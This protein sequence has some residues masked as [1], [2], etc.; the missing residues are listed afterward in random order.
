MHLLDDVVR[1]LDLASWRSV[2][3]SLVCAVYRVHDHHLMTPADDS[4]RSRVL[5]IRIGCEDGSWLGQQVF[6]ASLI[7]SSRDEMRLQIDGARDAIVVDLLPRAPPPDPAED[8]GACKISGAVGMTSANGAFP[9]GKRWI[10]RIVADSAADAAPPAPRRPPLTTDQL[11]RMKVTDLRDM[12]ARVGA[13]VPS[14]TRRKED[15]V[16]AIIS[17]SSS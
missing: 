4:D 1:S 12:M 8:S 9:V 10:V 3:K 16:R 5:M 6:H 17:S 11:M 14:G 7:A 2:V 15:I 13:S